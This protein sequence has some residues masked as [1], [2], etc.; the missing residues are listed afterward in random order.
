MTYKLLALDLD[1][2]LTNRQ[3]E[4]TA[5]TLAVLLRAQEKG[6]RVALA[7]GRPEQG[8]LPLARALRLERYG[9]FTA[10][11]NGGKIVDL[12]TGETVFQ[13]TL[14]PEI[15]PRLYRFAKTH[16]AALVTYD[17]C[18]VTEDEPDA[19]LELEAGINRMN[20]RRVENFL[21]YVSFPVTKC[22][23]MGEPEKMALLEGALRRELGDG[24]N[25]FRSEPFFLEVMPPRVDKAYSLSKLLCYLGLRRKELCAVGDGFNDL[26]MLQY[27]GLG[28]AMKNA[29]PA[30]KKAADYVTRHDNDHDGVAEVVEKFIL[31]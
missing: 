9:G 29:Q 19:Y 2:T 17:A 31:P 5:R 28:A 14:S 13:E 24:A 3:K 12:S 23:L 1:G 20:I 11:F 4:I 25:V 18:I 27:A 16:K 6:L 21:D 7:S 26:T 22:L 15:L 30:V 10:A 8:V